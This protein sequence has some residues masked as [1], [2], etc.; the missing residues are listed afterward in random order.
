[1]IATPVP[2]RSKSS[3]QLPLSPNTS[4]LEGNGNIPVI[5]RKSALFSSAYV[6]ERRP[7]KGPSLGPASCSCP[8][9]SQLQPAKTTSTPRAK[10]ALKKTSWIHSSKETTPRQPQQPRNDIGPF[11]HTTRATRRRILRRSRAPHSNHNVV[12]P[13]G[14]ISHEDRWAAMSD[15][16]GSHRQDPYVLD[17]SNRSL[18]AQALR[19]GMPPQAAHAVRVL[20][21]NGNAVGRHDLP[22]FLDTVWKMFPHLESLSLRGNPC[23]VP[24]GMRISHSASSDTDDDTDSKGNTTWTTR[25]NE[26]EMAIKAADHEFVR[27]QRLYILYR[28]PDLKI[29]DGIDVTEEER[30]LARPNSLSGRRVNGKEWLTGVMSTIT[31]GCEVEGEAHLD[32]DGITLGTHSSSE[33]SETLSIEEMRQVTRSCLEDSE[34]SVHDELE[35]KEIGHGRTHLS[36]EYSEFVVH[37]ESIDEEMGQGIDCSE[38]GERLKNDELINEEIG[39]GTNLS[40]D[41]GEGLINDELSVGTLASSEVFMMD[42]DGAVEVSLCDTFEDPQRELATTMLSKAVNQSLGKEDDS[43]YQRRSAVKKSQTR[44]EMFLQLSSK[45]EVLEAGNMTPPRRCRSA[46]MTCKGDKAHVVKTTHSEGGAEHCQT[47]SEDF[48]PLVVQGDLAF[49]NTKIKKLPKNDSTSPAL[50]TLSFDNSSADPDNY[51]ASKPLS[52]IPRGSRPPPC[53][54]STLRHFPQ[55]RTRRGR[56]KN[57]PGRRRGRRIPIVPTRSMIDI[58]ED[59]E[60]GSSGDEC[61]ALRSSW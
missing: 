29:I 1:M 17:L 49:L 57:K 18:S 14:L 35:N 12:D 37:N 13:A 61:V 25:R 46:G 34:L 47:S 59:D 31:I 30:E 11:P 3:P 40:S 45:A 39:Q 60:E 43:A 7:P 10:K 33:D 51:R 44:R 36:S 6:D 15:L 9:F 4:D 32:D 58:D 20:K 53:P 28:L 8:S 21:Y 41:D 5:K 26:L 27:M 22:E 16:A 23:S 55:A 54:T 52:E 2:K 19:Y 50:I 56:E 24:Y 48:H 38:N 42:V